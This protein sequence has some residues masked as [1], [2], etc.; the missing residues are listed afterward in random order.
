MIP[1]KQPLPDLRGGV[2]TPYIVYDARRDAYWFLFTGWSDPTGSKREGYA[3]PIDEALNVDLGKLRKILPSDFPAPAGYTN[4]AVRG[5]YN[6]ARDEFLVTSTHGEDAY[7]A[8]FGADWSLKG[9]KI[10]IKGFRKDSGLPIRPTGAYGNIRDALAVAPIGDSSAIGIF[11][12]RNVDELGELAV[13]DWGELGRWGAGNDVIDFTLM[14]RLQV[15]VEVDTPSRWVLQT[16]IGP[17]LDEVALSDLRNIAL[18]EA[19]LM[20]L[21]G[22]DDSFTQVGHPHYTTLPDGRPKL[23]LASFRDTWTRRPDTGREGYTHEIWAVYVDEA[24]FDPR[25]YGEL[26]GRFQGAESKWYYVPGAERLYVAVDGE[27][28]LVQ[29]LDLR[30]EVE[31]TVELSKG[32]NVVERPVTWVKIRAKAPV[33]AT[34]KAVMR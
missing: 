29:R 18:L 31:E 21:L 12:L 9:H 17:S 22:L 8:A 2:G 34:I 30:D 33:K 3:A 23:L 20:P 26:R 32:I 28:E 27:A 25:S 1:A 13:E 10:L 5:L 7:I 11:A 14:P 16:Y 4:N 24:I 6:E 19:S 15:F